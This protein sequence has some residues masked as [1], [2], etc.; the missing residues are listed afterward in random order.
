M[1]CKNRDETS[2]EQ[3][4]LSWKSTNSTRKSI[5]LYFKEK[6]NFQEC[7]ALNRLWEFALLSVI[8]MISDRTSETKPLVFFEQA[9]TQH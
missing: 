2:A 1:S 4:Q 6:E 3:K 5:R 7:M 8:Q 9:T